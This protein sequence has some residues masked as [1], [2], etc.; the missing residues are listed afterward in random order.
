[1]ALISQWL[2]DDNVANTHVDDSQTANDGVLEGGDNT[3]DISI[4]GPA[5]VANTSLLF[6]GTDDYISIANDINAAPDRTFTFTC[7]AKTTYASAT[8][9]YMV[10]EANTLNGRYA[11]LLIENGKCVFRIQPVAS[12]VS[13]I[14][15]T[16][17][18]DGFWHYIAATGEGS[19]NAMT[20]YVD[21]RQDANKGV[22]PGGA[23]GLETDRI[24]QLEID[25]G[26][27]VGGYWQGGLADARMYDASLSF[28]E[29]VA[30]GNEMISFGDPNS[31]YLAK[32]SNSPD[33]VYSPNF[34]SVYHG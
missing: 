7:W 4:V 21:G 29:M 30:V 28:T 9:R 33:S 16:D 22:F 1:M 11:A 10:T 3:D 31:L 32:L 34:N 15:I 26:L 13:V 23:F 5:G 2:M 25:T 27:E 8:P 17:I 6:D 18:S 14:G 12:I 19:G 24:G 20:L